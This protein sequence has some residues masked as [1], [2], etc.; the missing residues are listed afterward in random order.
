MNCGS[1]TRRIRQAAAL[2]SAMVSA[3]AFS[4]CD[5][6]TTPGAALGP[7]PV[8]AGVLVITAGPIAINP[9]VLCAT[10]GLLTTDLNVVVSSTGARLSVDQVTLHLIDGTNIGGPGVTFPQPDLNARFANTVVL[11]GSSRTFGLTP[12]F[13]CGMAAP[14]SVQ[15]EVGV[16]DA[17]GRR[18]V[19]TASMTLP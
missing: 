1:Q 11:A 2:L 19:M 12:T 7:A 5:R 6:S 3:C 14:R 13:R 10:S 9:A 15:G 17:S 16:V 8:P 18:S 4:G